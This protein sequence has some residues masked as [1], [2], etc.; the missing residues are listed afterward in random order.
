MLAVAV[1]SVVKL[2]AFLAVGLSVCLLLFDGVGD[3]CTRARAEA[4]DRRPRA[5][6]RRA[7]PASR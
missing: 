6:H 2:A 4:G 1:E 3:L 5:G 7:R